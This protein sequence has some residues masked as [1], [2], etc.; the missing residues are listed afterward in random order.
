MDKREVIIE[1][2]KA[3]RALVK[4]SFPIPVEQFYLFGSYAKGTSHKDSDIDVALVVSHLGDDYDFLTTEPLLWRLKRQVDCRIE[5][6]V[7]SRDT[8]YASMLDE[9]KRTG[10][11]VVD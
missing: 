5:P 1:K 6:H 10:I 11:E 2:V 8:D 3:Y 9:V 4:S 7:I